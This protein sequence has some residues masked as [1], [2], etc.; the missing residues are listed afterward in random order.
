MVGA[1]SPRV[2]VIY[3]RLKSHLLILYSFGAAYINV[4][5]FNIKTSEI[6][7]LSYKFSSIAKR[8][9]SINKNMTRIIWK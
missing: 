3:K 7:I 2:N 6:G 9:Y 8:K 1:L 4:R 5:K